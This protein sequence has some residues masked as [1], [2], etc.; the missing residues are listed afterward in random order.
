MK[1]FTLGFWPRILRIWF[2]VDSFG[3]VLG[4]QLKIIPTKKKRSQKI[5]H[6]STS[7]TPRVQVYME[8]E[9]STQIG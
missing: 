4:F 1:Y 5:P 2:G 3:D 6:H 7:R 9:I 8:P